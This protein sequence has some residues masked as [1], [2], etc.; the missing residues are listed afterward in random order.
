MLLHFYITDKGRCS[1]L[2]PH[3]THLVLR[4]LFLPS[5]ESMAIKTSS[6]E[7]V[8]LLHTFFIVITVTPIISTLASIHATDTIDGGGIA[9]L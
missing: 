2:S 8:T 6:L 9:C 7:P 5:S 3:Q 1:E 4:R